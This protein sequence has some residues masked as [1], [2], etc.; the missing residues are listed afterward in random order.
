MLVPLAS[1]LAL[2]LFPRS[3][4]AEIDSD[5]ERL[6]RFGAITIGGL[7]YIASEAVFKDSLSPDHCRWCDDNGVDAGVRRGLV[8][9]DRNV[10]HQLSNA[11]GYVTAPLLAASLLFISSR[12]VE[13]GRWTRFADDVIP[14][15]ESV[16]YSQLIVQAVKFSVGR[17]RPFV[18]YASSPL[19]PE[20]DQN[21]SFLSGHSALTFA[22][23]TSAGMVAHRR[24]YALEPVI[25]SSG[26]VLAVTTAYLRIAAD[27]HYATDVI[28]GSVFGAAAGLL[29]PRL[30]GSL[31]ERA[32]LAPTTSPI[33]GLTF[34]TTF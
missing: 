19:D 1:V 7:A 22:I 31:P 23:A 17:A 11:T 10:A 14:M 4:R 30:T 21:L 2:V 6:V 20:P 3:A 18:R 5:R 13:S 32:T 9:D 25:W 24:G 15:L 8:W 29:V 12:D 26:L 34:A 33:M 27:K 28:A 16:I